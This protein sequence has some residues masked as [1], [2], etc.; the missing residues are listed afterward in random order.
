[1]TVSSLRERQ[2]KGGD[3]QGSDTSLTFSQKFVITDFPLT[4][5]VIWISFSKS[6]GEYFTLLETPPP[7]LPRDTLTQNLILN[8]L[9]KPTPSLACLL[10]EQLPVSGT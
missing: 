5:P 9:V 7:L 1:M 4:T 10:K 2:I 3:S 6:P 8:N